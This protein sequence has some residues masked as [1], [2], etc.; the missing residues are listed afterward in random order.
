MSANKIYK[1]TILKENSN[2]TWNLAKLYVNQTN[3]PLVKDWSNR[4]IMVPV[5]F[6]NNF[7]EILNF[8][9]REDDTW[10]V[11]VMKSG[12]TWTQ[13]LAW[14]IL[15]NYDFET[16][17]TKVLMQRSPYLEFSINKNRKPSTI[18]IAN[19]LPSPRLLKSHMPASALPSDIWEKKAKIIYVTRNV[20]DVVVS[21]Y[22]FQSG[23][24]LFT[25]SIDEFVE[26]FMN[27]SLLNLPFWDHVLEFW[28]MRNDP[29]IF[30]T[31]YERLKKDIRSVILELCKFLEKPKPSEEI[32]E[33]MVEHLDFENMKN[34]HAGKLQQQRI[35]KLKDE[36]NNSSSDFQF[37]RRGIVG[38]YKDE[39]STD[40][41]KKLDQWTEFHL[42]KAGVTSEELFG[43]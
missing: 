42:R 21:N 5:N 38:S 3:I 22:R 43:I 6:A 8:K 1:S 16:A 18:E 34:S 19:N 15:N 36:N 25:G 33:K 26:Y 20:K 35:D 7:D 17:S 28:Q 27:G 10:V 4:S 23:L 31:S 30:F 9:R 24:G 39:L 29:K 11:T 13:E 14:L 37:M 32:L 2:L 41:A 12:T 40:L